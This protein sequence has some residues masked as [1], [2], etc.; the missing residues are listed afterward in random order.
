[1]NYVELSRV[2]TIVSSIT[3]IIGLYSQAW[4]IWRTKSA[5]DFTGIL[6]FAMVLTE[7]VWLNY[8]IAIKEWPIIV[9]ETINVPGIILIAFLF[10][11]YR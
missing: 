9:L 10:I 2:L 6:I 4:K 1:M 11:K 5:K 7:L 8:G 3:I